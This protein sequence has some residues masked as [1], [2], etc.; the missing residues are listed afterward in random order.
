MSPFLRKKDAE[1]Y[2]AKS[3]GKVLSFE[4]ALKAALTGG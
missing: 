3:G 1:D 4:D 2:D